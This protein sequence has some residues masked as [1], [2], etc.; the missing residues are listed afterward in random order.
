MHFGG[1][2][3]PFQSVIALHLFCWAGNQDL[4]E[5]YVLRF[6]ITRLFK[7]M[8]SNGLAHRSSKIRAF[9]IFTRSSLIQFENTYQLNNADH[10]SPLFIQ[11]GCISDYWR[12]V[13]PL[14][15]RSCEYLWNRAYRLQPDIP[16]AAACFIAKRLVSHHANFFLQFWLSGDLLNRFPS[17]FHLTWMPLP[18]KEL[19]DDPAHNLLDEYWTSSESA[20]WKKFDSNNS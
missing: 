2:A 13:K 12:A 9:L 19:I 17:R 18:T 15:L 5:G 1:R 10:L 4:C 7:R 16:R 20:F 3:N 8:D 14:Q 6:C 11:N